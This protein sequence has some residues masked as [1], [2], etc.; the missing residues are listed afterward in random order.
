MKMETKNKNHPPKYDVIMLFKNAIILFL[1]MFLIL[2][3][4]LLNITCENYEKELLKVNN[5]IELTNTENSQ[6]HNKNNKLT[7]IISDYETQITELK[8]NNSILFQKNEEYKTI[9]DNVN[10][11]ENITNTINKWEVG[12]ELPLPNIPSNMKLCTDYRFYNIVGTPHN[13][14]QKVAWTDDFGCRRYNDD[15]IVGLGSF[16][17]VDIG[18]RFEITLDTGK[19]FTIILGDGKADCDTDINNMFTPCYNYEGE[20]CANILEFIID[21]E[22]MNKKAYAYGSVDYYNE[23]KGNIVKMVYLGRDQGGDWTSYE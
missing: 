5:I 22:A 15:Y 6:L 21:K 8:L 13:R 20:Y 1:I 17:S 18:D 23:F 19:T 10:N 16:Y 4:I 3:L 7:A 11:T 9:L 12:Q 2:T 14:L